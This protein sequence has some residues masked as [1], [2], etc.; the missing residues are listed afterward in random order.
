[1]DLSKW[2]ER[3]VAKMHIHLSI[4]EPGDNWLNKGFIF[5]RGF[6]PIPGWDLSVVWLSEEGMPK[7]G[8]LSFDMFAGDGKRLLGCCVDVKLRQM[9]TSLVLVEQRD[10][11][12][13]IWRKDQ[14]CEEKITQSQSGEFSNVCFD[15][16]L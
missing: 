16:F 9:L 11:E 5:D 4:I 7:K 14:L 2:E 15:G 13:E 10:Y 8:L 6:N 3:Q 1:L 12:A